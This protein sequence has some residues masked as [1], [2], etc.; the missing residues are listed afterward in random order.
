VR[1]S[2]VLDCFLI[3]R[4]GDENATNDDYA[5]VD[6]NMQ[7][8]VVADGMGGRPG[9]AEASRTATVTFLENVK[10]AAQSRID[11]ATL[12]SAV[13]A[14]NRKVRSLSEADPSLSGL[15][16]TLSAVVLSGNKGKIVHVG[17]SR[18][19]I[20]G[21][22][23]L[24]QIT[25]DHTLVAELLERKHISPEGAKRYPMRNVLSRC[26]GPQETVEPDIF[27]F[28]LRPGDWLLLATDG[29]S[30][31]LSEDQLRKTLQNSSMT[32]AERVCGDVMRTAAQHSL[33]DDAT[34]IVARN[35]RG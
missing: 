8:L 26:I 5:A 14:A 12:R 4:Q 23:G 22:G 13:A 9:G 16:T 32:N 15:G 1:L 17:D 31:S 28:E 7:T 20:F 30:K 24:C 18:V 21:K 2:T 33:M 3:S 29:L 35:V 19:Y 34:A 25:R 27:D 10:S 6:I 11:V